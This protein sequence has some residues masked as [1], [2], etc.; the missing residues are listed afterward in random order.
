MPPVRP[1]AHAEILVIGAGASG[2]VQS[3]TLAEAGRRVVCLDQGGWTEPARHPHHGADFVHRRFT[4]WNPEPAARRGPDDYP[5]QGDH[6]HALM[7]NGVGGST[8]VFAALWPRFRPSDFR[9]GREH[10]LAPDWPITYAE[11]APFYDAADQLI[12]VSGLAGDP[13]MPPRPA[14]PCAPLPLRESGRA[15]ARGFDQLGWHWWPMPVG[16]ISEP[17][18]GRAPCNGCGNCGVRVPPR[19]HGQAV[20]HALAACAGGGRPACGPAPA[21]Q[22][23]RDRGWTGTATGADLYR[24][25][26]TGN[27]RA[28]DGRH[29]DRAGGQRRRHPPPAA[30]ICHRAAPERGLANGNDVVG[31]YLMH[32]TLVAAEIWVEAPHP[33]AIS[34]I[35]AP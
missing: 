10:G 24:P 14:Y 26:R 19:L 9:K 18:D 29:R 23:D 1:P 30:A 11:L 5:I 16:T 31:R 35:P 12:G 25:V 22:S 6:S 3:L 33:L 13:G 21:S 17:Y 20:A 8:N 32:H 2:V 4:D 28:P 15:I 27:T 7:W 34:A